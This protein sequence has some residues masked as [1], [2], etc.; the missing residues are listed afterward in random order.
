MKLEYFYSVFF[1]FLSLFISLFLF[2]LFYIIIF[3]KNDLEKLS[4][5]ECGFNPFDD[6]YGRFD[7][8]FY[9]VAI[10]Y[11]IFDLEVTF[12]FPC[13]SNIFLLQFFSIFIIFLFLFI[14][15]LGFLYEWKRGALEWQ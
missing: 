14:L 4:S 1:I 6:V 5:Y 12:I 2:L 10:L 9:L 3:R 13:I 7:V 8:K 15:T 11:L